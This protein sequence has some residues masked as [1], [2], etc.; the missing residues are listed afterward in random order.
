MGYEEF[1]G[2]GQQIPWFG[3]GVAL[4]V[5]ACIMVLISVGLVLR[6]RHRERVLL[7]R[8]DG[9]LDAAINGDFTIASFDESLLSE[10]EAK[11]G[12]YLSAS[13]L[14]A[15]NVSEEKEEIKQLI[16]DLSHQTKTP[17]TNLLLYTEFLAEQELSTEGC[18]YVE[19]LRGQA[20]RLEFFVESFVKASRLETGVFRFHKKETGATDLL[21][22]VARQF[23][24]GA[25]EKGIKLCIE[26]TEASYVIKM[27]VKWTEEALGNLVDNAIKYTPEGG[28]VTLRAIPYE[29]FWKID[30]EDNGI[31]ISEE[32]RSKVFSRFYR[33]AAVA[34]TEGIGIGLYL[35]RRIVSGQGGY[36]K[37]TDGSEGG[38]VVSVFLPRD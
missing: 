32:E 21:E 13:A 8:L 34:E 35:V 27:D 30:V 7:K 18:S 2:S 19:M 12:K 20:K 24:M 23:E 26:E 16:S 1:V 28:K 3:I 14:S 10:V 17:I 25:R 37:L 29:M 9:M 31:G 4:C 38:T 33:S 22:R 11:F 5:L 15:K 36:V 6:Y